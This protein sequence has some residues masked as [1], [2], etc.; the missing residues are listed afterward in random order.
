MWAV[1]VSVIRR[2][3]G[4]LLS[5]VLQAAVE[6]ADMYGP[7]MHTA[8][9]S[10]ASGPKRSA[11]DLRV[12]LAKRAVRKG[13]R[14]KAATQAYLDRHLSMVSLICSEGEH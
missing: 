13:N 12:M 10:N 5:P 7:A 6:S 4:A 1:A 11:S 14:S 2:G 9:R 3:V 8:P